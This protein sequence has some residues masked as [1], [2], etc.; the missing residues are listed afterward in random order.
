MNIIIHFLKC[1]M[2]KVIM[3]YILIDIARRILNA[4]LLKI[5]KTGSKL[6]V[7]K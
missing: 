3:D 5:V 1:K 4:E 7:Q 6:T 2:T